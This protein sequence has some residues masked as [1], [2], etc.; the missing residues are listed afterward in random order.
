MGSRKDFLRL[1]AFDLDFED[2]MRLLRQAGNSTRDVQEPLVLCF[3]YLSLF[4]IGA[5]GKEPACQFRRHKRCGFDPW[6]GK[7]PRRRAW[8]PPLQYPCLVDPMARGA[9]QATVHGVAKSQ[10][11]SHP[12]V[13]GVVGRL[14][15]LSSCPPDLFWQLVSVS[16]QG[17]FGLYFWASEK[18]PRPRLN[19]AP[20]PGYIMTQTSECLPS[21]P[22][23]HQRG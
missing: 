20:C 16:C 9:W 22:G 10:T 5:S 23:P 6:V 8:Q 17:A 7:I 13:V 12:R 15:A 14:S 18:E 1:V 19:T 2:Y 3:I 11:S 4:Y 21:T